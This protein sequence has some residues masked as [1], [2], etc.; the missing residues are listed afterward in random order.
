MAFKKFTD[1]MHDDYTGGIKKYIYSHSG[2]LSVTAF[3]NYFDSCCLENCYKFVLF[4]VG[5]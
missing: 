3:I 2:G 5:F 1:C 4:A